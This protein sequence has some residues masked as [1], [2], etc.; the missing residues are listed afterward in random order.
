MAID[1]E[2]KAI[3]TAVQNILSD[4]TVPVEK[5]ANVIH[6]LGQSLKATAKLTIEKPRTQESID[7]DKAEY[8]DKLDA[9]ESL[10]LLKR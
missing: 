10:E 1:K 6:E 8:L 5:R 3:Q 4:E 9:A 7:A 2:L